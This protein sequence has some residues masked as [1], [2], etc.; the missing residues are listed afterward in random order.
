MKAFEQYFPVMATIYHAAQF[1]VS[2]MNSEHVWPLKPS[3]LSSTFLWWSLICCTMAFSDRVSWRA[4]DMSDLMPLTAVTN[5][6]FNFLCCWKMFY[7]TCCGVQRT[8]SRNLE[9]GLHLLR[10]IMKSHITLTCDWQY[11]V[12]PLKNSYACCPAFCVFLC[13]TSRGN[14][15]RRKPTSLPG[16]LLFPSPLAPGDRKKR[17]PGNEVGRK[18]AA[19]T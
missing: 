9:P 16:S 13:F 12:Y 18:R 8:K 17:G 3:L 19:A 7:R 14:C 11:T 15:S 1:W 2:F 5:I 6:K 4:L 10:M